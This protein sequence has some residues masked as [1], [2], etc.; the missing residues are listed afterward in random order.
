VPSHGLRALRYDLQASHPRRVVEG[1]GRAA[2][3][4]ASL[5]F[6]L[7][8]R[9]RNAAR[10]AGWGPPRLYG[11]AGS[12]CGGHER[13]TWRTFKRRRDPQLGGQGA[14][15][16][17][18][19]RV[20]SRWNFPLRTAR[21][22]GP[23]ESARGQRTRSGSPLFDDI[24]LQPPGNMGKLND[25]RCGSKPFVHD[26]SARHRLRSRRAGPGR[27]ADLLL[28]VRA[29]GATTNPGTAPGVM[30]H[31]TTRSSTDLPE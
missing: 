19:G 25:S 5:L 6:P 15:W 27:E 2:R 16:A 18:G 8:G 12:W 31:R 4:T 28:R 1:A 30:S 22:C 11:W 24:G 14:A 20:W 17:V 26:C 21:P 9:V 7:G 13:Q 3:R 10:D 29:G 23:Q